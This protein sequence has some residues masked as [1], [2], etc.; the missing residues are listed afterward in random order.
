[1]PTRRRIM[2]D[3]SGRVGKCRVCGCTRRMSPLQDCL[4][5]EVP[6]VRV[7]VEW[8]HRYEYRWRNANGEWSEPEIRYHNATPSETDARRRHKSCRDYSFEFD[9]EFEGIWGYAGSNDQLVKRT[10]RTT[11]MEEVISEND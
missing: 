3:F 9:H 7:Q 11:I 8:V 4:P 5:E 10:T 6:E 2:H 1:M